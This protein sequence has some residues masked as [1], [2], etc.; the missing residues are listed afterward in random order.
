MEIRT[1]SRAAALVLLVVSLPACELVG[2]GGTDFQVA[3]YDGPPV[4]ED[5]RM[6]WRAAVRDDGTVTLRFSADDA[7]ADLG[8]GPDD[9]PPPPR[10]GGQRWFLDFRD[11]PGALPRLE[12][13][14]TGT[15]GGVGQERREAEVY[16]QSWDPEGIAAGE[17]RLRIAG[18]RYVS[19]FWVDLAAAGPTL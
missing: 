13:V 1:A 8:L 7:R 16:V 6:G 19:P 14:W 12:R 17:V 15:I 11:E 2:L 4:T 5:A 9:D 3:A 10:G 18:A